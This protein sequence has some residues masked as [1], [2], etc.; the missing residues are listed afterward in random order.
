MAAA[1]TIIFHLVYFTYRV[2]SELDVIRGDMEARERNG[3]SLFY[4]IKLIVFVSLFFT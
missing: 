3:F 2:C 4:A 1:L